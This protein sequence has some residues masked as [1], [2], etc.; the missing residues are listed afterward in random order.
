MISPKSRSQP[1]RRQRLRA[2]ALWSFVIAGVGFIG[3]VAGVIQYL[4]SS[5]VSIRSGVQAVSGQAAFGSL[6]GLSLV[7]AAFAVLGMFFRRRAARQ[8]AG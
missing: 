7:S 1:S 3:V 4:F 8:G 6:L 2:Q 5:Q